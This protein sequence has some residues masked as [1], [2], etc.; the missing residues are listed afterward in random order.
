MAR[1]GRTGTEREGG[2]D[3]GGQEKKIDVFLH[4]IAP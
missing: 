3:E 1:D 4:H 2:E